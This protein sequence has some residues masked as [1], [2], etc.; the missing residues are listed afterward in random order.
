MAC[1]ALLPFAWAPSEVP[2][3]YLLT[4]ELP[5]DEEIDVV[6]RLRRLSGVHF[7]LVPKAVAILIPATRPMI[8]EINRRDTGRTDWLQLVRRRDT[9]VIC[10]DP[11]KQPGPDGV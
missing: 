10:V 9:V 4:M 8:R 3:G 2:K 11:N 6:E 7:T 1:P 5:S